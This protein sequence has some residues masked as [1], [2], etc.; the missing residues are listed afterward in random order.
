MGENSWWVYRYEIGRNGKL[1]QKSRVVF[2]GNS[3]A[4]ADQ[5][6]ER[7]KEEATIYMLSGN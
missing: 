2:F 7:Q 5:W 6:I 1:S 3:R 4:E